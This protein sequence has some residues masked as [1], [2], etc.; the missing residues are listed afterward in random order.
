M[1]EVERF[2]AAIRAA[3]AL[4]LKAIP[5]SAS[6]PED[7]LAFHLTAVGI[8][9]YRQHRIHPRRRFRADFY[10]PAGRL[11]VEVN[12]G[13]FMQ[14]RHS[15]GKGMESDGEKSWFIAMMPAR[16][17]TVTPRHIKTGQAL[18]W[19]EKALEIT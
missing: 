9:F 4:P 3:I 6:A 19:I 13:G 7:T 16:L 10:F 1:E 18:D 12:G 8:E 5:G 11:V 2:Q 17:I 14:G 15:R